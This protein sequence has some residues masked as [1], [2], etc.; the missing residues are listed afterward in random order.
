[1]HSAGVAA[2]MYKEGIVVSVGNYNIGSNGTLNAGEDYYLNPGLKRYDDYVISDCMAD[3][4]VKTY[5]P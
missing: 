1:M 3:D 4:Q 2:V 5:N